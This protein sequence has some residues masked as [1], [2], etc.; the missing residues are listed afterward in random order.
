MPT[1]PLKVAGKYQNKTYSLYVNRI[2]KNLHR[3]KSCRWNSFSRRETCNFK[4]SSSRWKQKDMV[5]GWSHRNSKCY[6]SFKVHIG[7]KYLKV[8]AGVVADAF[9]LSIRASKEAR[10]FKNL[11]DVPIPGKKL[12]QRLSS[13]VQL[14]TLYSS[15]RPFGTNVIVGSFDADGPA[16]HMIESSGLCYVGYLCQQCD[17]PQTDAF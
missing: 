9:H 5:S 14:F 13:Y 2:I 10:A 15:V 16:I 8:S 3:F 12:A 11:Y 1:R 6:I 7:S 4:A 17:K